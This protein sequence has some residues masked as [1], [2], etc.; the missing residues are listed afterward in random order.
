[1]SNEINVLQTLDELRDHYYRAPS[2]L[3]TKR[4]KPVPK[5]LFEKYTYHRDLMMS[6]M[7]QLREYFQ[8]IPDKPMRIARYH[9]ESE[10]DEEYKNIL[11]TLRP[12]RT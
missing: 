12:R 5:A 4:A 7:M 8:P 1:M 3:D 6:S 9:P 11:D 2:T 10:G